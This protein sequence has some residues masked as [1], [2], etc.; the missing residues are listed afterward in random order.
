MKKTS[1]AARL[2]AV[3]VAAVTTA[4]VTPASA[5]SGGAVPSR[6][7]YI[8]QRAVVIHG[9]ANKAD[10]TVLAIFY[11]RE[12]LDFND[13][14]A[15]R[16]LLLDREGKVA[17]GIGGSLYAVGSY[18]FMG[19]ID[20]YKFTTYD[21]AVPNSPDLRQRFGADARYSSLT[22]KLVGKA[23]KLGN[24]SVY[25]QAK[26][27]GDDG[28]YGF[29]LK[30]A[31]ATLGHVTAGLAN[32]T[33]VDGS[34][35]APTIDPQGASGQVTEKNMLFRYTTSSYRGLKGAISIEVPS[36]SITAGKMMRPG[37]TDPQAAAKKIAQRVPDIPAY[38]QYGWSG[39]HVRATAMLRNLVYRD[40]AVD[41]WQGANK[42]V[43]GW[44]VKLSAIGQCGSYLK[45]FGHISYGKGISSYVNDLSGNGYDLVPDGDTGRL[46]AAESMT[47]TFGTYVYITPKLFLT[48][49]FSR[50]QVFGCR[51]MGGDSFRYAT[52]GCANAF[53]N[54][55][56]NLRFGAEYLHGMRKN[57]DGQ[58]GTAN[59]IN[60]LLQ[61][62]F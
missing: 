57:Y 37:E 14:D 49:S 29:K 22:A 4:S 26:F 10:S 15:P 52:Y 20:S 16:F 8:P 24:F 28:A 39:G 45:P 31:Y 5:Q 35:Q 48:G 3:V 62:S 47:W 12:D 11:S 38:V 19:A 59:R 6:P 40:L 25:F 43:T 55:D 50:A 33:F 60:V 1:L 7:E 34:V 61:Y 30:Q 44:G 32:S 36:V 13:P 9:D 21:I 51:D 53:Y 58:T 46:K 18:D 42:F 54:V 27:Q 23:G 17:F 2:A 56:D 41:N